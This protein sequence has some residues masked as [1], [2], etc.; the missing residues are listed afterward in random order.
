LF[1]FYE[2]SKRR[3]FDLPKPDFSI[4][5]NSNYNLRLNLIPL[6]FILVEHAGINKRRVKEVGNEEDVII[7]VMR[8]FISHINVLLENCPYL[9]TSICT[10]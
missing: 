10:S 5:A 1:L 7:V 2:L 6:I 9:A 4:E 8:E 3:N